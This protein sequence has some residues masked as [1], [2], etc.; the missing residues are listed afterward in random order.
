MVIF[1][2]L[3]L[4]SYFLNMIQKRA[5]INRSRIKNL[6]FNLFIILINAEYKNT[7][8]LKCTYQIY[9]FLEEEQNIL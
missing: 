4:S 6:K 2:L 5:S 9:K 1:L 8:V 7:N 3:N